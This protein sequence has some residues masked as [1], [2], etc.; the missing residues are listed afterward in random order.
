MTVS[1]VAIEKC[2]AFW[3]KIAKENGWYKEPFYV[4]VWVDE[5]GEITDSVSFRG[6]TADIIAED[7]EDDEED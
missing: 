1:K 4:Q 2:R 7:E 6:M 5:S 3:A